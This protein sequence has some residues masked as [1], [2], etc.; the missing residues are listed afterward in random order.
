FLKIGYGYFL[1]SLFQLIVLRHPSFRFL[2]H[3]RLNTEFQSCDLFLCC[4]N[5]AIA[6][7]LIGRSSLW[8]E[9]YPDVA[10][11][12][13]PIVPVHSSAVVPAKAVE[14]DWTIHFD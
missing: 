10:V 5:N 4:F 13:F 7:E 9:E 1:S 3:Y 6:I 2:K 12:K 14:F 11:G 8:C